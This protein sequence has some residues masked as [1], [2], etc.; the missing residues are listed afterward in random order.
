MHYG[1]CIIIQMPGKKLKCLL[2]LLLVDFSLTV[3][4]IK[5]WVVAVALCLVFGSSG[6]H[7]ILLDM[8]LLI[9]EILLHLI[10]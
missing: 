7:S 3:K 2:F 9:A 10:L 8:Y 6:L 5:V 1:I 4:E